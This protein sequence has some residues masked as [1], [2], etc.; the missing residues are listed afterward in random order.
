MSERERDWMRVLAKGLFVAAAIVLLLSLV[1][2]VSIAGSEST[3][4]GVDE[5]QRENRGS[6]A[7]ATIAFGI[8]SSAV[9]CG[10]GGIMRLLMAQLPPAGAGSPSDETE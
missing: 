1:A 7:F 5:I 8:V 3:V 2:G 10:L 4:P 9:L 6:I